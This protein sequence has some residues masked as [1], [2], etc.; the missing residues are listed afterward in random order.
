MRILYIH[1][2]FA[3]RKGQTGTRS[4]EFGRFLAA[5]GHAVTVITSGLANA[6]FPVAEGEASHSY[7][8]GGIRVL[9]V[10][11]GYNDPHVG[12]ATNGWQRM[13]KFHEFA[14]MVVRVGQRQE[15]P[16]V[17]FA[18]HTPLQV[19]LAGAALGRY[20]AVP[21]VFE[22][23][24]LWPE[25][26]VNIGALTNPFAVW[27]LR[28]MARKIY[29]SAEHI[30]ALSP[31]MKEGVERYGIAADKV[32]VIPNASDLDLFRPDLDGSASRERLGF[33]DRFAAIYFGAMGMANGLEYVIEAARI[34][35]HRGRDGIVLVLHGSGG[36]RD[37]LERLSRS[38]GLTNV[39]FSP[40]VPDKEE[41]ARIVAGGDACLTIY[42]ASKEHTWSPNKMFDALAA[43]KPVV[44]NVPGWLGE[45]IE[46]N[47]CGRYVDPQR[48]EALADALEELSR[49]PALCRRMGEN[50]RFLAERQFD[51]R[52][53]AARLEDVL[54]TAVTR[55]GAARTLEALPGQAG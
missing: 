54:I 26:L 44:I 22:V 34:L 10:A 16:D 53:L 1:Q 43:G 31:G 55:F 20:F 33:G 38:Y 25:A 19:G 35:A 7:E 48:P 42:R 8:V 14:R 46:R 45:T 52:V 28:R 21:F 12:T 41:V 11:A 32:T 50:A 29:A 17:I 23:R 36:Q 24:D 27:W 5:R 51:R 3:S 15:P 37:A 18:T 39:V 13:R 6:E 47:R 4:Y 49:D 40:L 9:S 30:V 2:Y